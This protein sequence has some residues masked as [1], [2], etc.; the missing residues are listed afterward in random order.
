MNEGWLSDEHFI[1]FTP[2]ESANAS[3]KYGIEK[4]LPGFIVVGLRGWNDFLVKNVE[5]HTFTV[6][7]V[8][9]DLKYMQ[10][11]AVPEATAKLKQDE[12]FAGKIKWYLK[13]PIFGGDASDS[14][15]N[16][17]T[18]EQHQQLVAFWNKQYRA[19]KGMPA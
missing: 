8:P 13:P 2:G 12:R 18:H 15:T 10:P 5:G 11:I 1:L 16:W 14:N 4:L 9:V 3:A 17:V 7:T 19:L 6:P